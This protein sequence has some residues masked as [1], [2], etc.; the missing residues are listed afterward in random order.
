[1]IY[2][3]MLYEVGNEWQSFFVKSYERENTANVFFNKRTIF[4]TTK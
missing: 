4:E 2:D 1:M 3:M